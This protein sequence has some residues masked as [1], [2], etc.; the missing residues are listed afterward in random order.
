[1]SRDQADAGSG[2]KKHL[3][4]NIGLIIF[5]IIFL[6]MVAI[7]I[8]YLTKNHI[9][10]CEV[11]PGRIVDSDSFTGFIIR[12]ENLVGAVKS[13]YVNYFINDGDRAAKN[14][15]VCMIDRRQTDTN[16][17]NIQ[18]NT[19]YTFN[20]SDYS[21]IREQI[22]TFKKNFSENDY[23]DVYNL[24]YQLN[25]IVS[26]IVSRNNINTMNTASAG[27]N[28]DIMKA[29]E[30]GIISYAYDRLEGYSAEDMTVELFTSRN[31]EKVQL[32]AGTW[33][34]SQSPAYKMIYDD[35]WQII[36]YP[37]EE[38]LKKLKDLDYV[39]IILSRDEIT[40]TADVNVFENDGTTFVSL[41]LTNYMIRY[42]NDRYIDVEIVWDSHEGLKIPKSAITTKD[43]YMIPAEYVVTKEETSERGFWVDTAEGP[44]FIK[45]VI[46]SQSDDFC[47]VDCKDVS[48]GTVLR[49]TSSGKTYTVS[50]TAAL[51]GVYNI[52]KGYAMFRLIDILYEYGDY[53]I[54]SNETNYGV[55]LYDHIILDGDSVRE[56][57]II[58]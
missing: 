15:N 35:N 25:S 58:Y 40:I 49:Q 16:N 51:K 7:G 48:A 26:R 56:N 42:C 30:A 14:S 13:G 37:T 31:Y 22:T 21:S 11:Q 41:G 27:S 32:A 57:Q 46:Y 8:M 1:M 45:P 38:Q 5:I 47:Y 44:E 39:D 17:D 53:C 3:K 4:I 29:A 50:S 28:Y 10:F 23:G 34:E 20:D 33:V 19:V 6:Y 52:N 12:N 36:I 2:G 9:S 18:N 55:T 54:I 43:F 24:D